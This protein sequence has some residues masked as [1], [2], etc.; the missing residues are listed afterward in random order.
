MGKRAITLD[1]G[2]L[3]GVHELK[4]GDHFDLLASV[5]VDMPGQGRSSSGQSGTN[6]MATPDA[7]LLPK[8]GF[9]RPLVEDGVVVTP[10]KIRNVPTTVSSL[11]QGATTRTTPVQ[12]I[13]LA[14][15][16]EEVRLVA[17]A[18][19]LKYEITCVA[20]SGRPEPAADSPASTAHSSPAA[21]I[22]AS[23][24]DGSSPQRPLQPA[25]VL[26]EP[27]HGDCCRTRTHDKAC[28]QR[29]GC[30]GRYHARTGP[31]GRRPLSGVPDRCATAIHAL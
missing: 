22:P 20:R 9:V 1:A 27:P 31:H 13:V 8:R 11:T 17:E 23:R 6:V 30:A 24:P 26:H 3:K 21:G 29:G 10:V 19:D 7:L 25:E 12:E 2:K 4:E 16:P 14:V 28:R 15:A 18:L 5:A